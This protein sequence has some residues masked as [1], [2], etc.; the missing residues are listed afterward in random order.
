MS[1]PSMGVLWLLGQPQKGRLRKSTT[2]EDKRTA[3]WVQHHDQSSGLQNTFWSLGRVRAGCSKTD[4]GMHVSMHENKY[5]CFFCKSV[6]FIAL[7]PA[8]NSVDAGYITEEKH[9]KEPWSSAQHEELIS[10]NSHVQTQ[11]DS[12]AAEIQNLPVRV[13]WEEVLLGVC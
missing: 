9:S 10:T 13:R 12:L 8:Q 7:K 4:Q 1:H 3:W 2:H 11:S 6:S 5:P